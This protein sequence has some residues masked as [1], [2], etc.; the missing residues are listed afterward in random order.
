M[1]A[2]VLDREKLRLAGERAEQLAVGAG[3]PGLQAEGQDL[4]EQGFAP[5]AVEMRRRL[6]QQQ[7]RRLPAAALVRRASA[8]AIDSSSAFCSPVEHS[9]AR[10]GALPR[11]RPR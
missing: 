8:S 11:A 2:A 10:S 3:E 4:A 9:A 6:V 1:D 7:D 5:L